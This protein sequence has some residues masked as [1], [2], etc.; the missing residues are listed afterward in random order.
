MSVAACSALVLCYPKY[1]EVTLASNNKCLEVRN[2]LCKAALQVWPGIVL[3][4]VDVVN[5]CRTLDRKAAMLMHGK[6]T[7]PFQIACLLQ[8]ILALRICPLPC[9]P[10][11]IRI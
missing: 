4:T 9:P 5:A 3:E 2:Y 1:S 10:G 7:E 11:A 8:R 6:T